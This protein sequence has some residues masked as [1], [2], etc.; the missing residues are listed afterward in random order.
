MSAALLAGEDEPVIRVNGEG[1]SP[2]VLVC[3]HAGR[4]IPKSLGT[5]ALTPRELESHIAWDI[6]AEGVARRLADLLDAPLFLQRYSRLVYDCNRPPDVQS[7][8]PVVSEVTRIPG[9]EHLSPEAK[10]ARV[11]ALYR[12]LHGAV[13]AFLDERAVRG[14]ASIF[15][16]IHSFTPV[17]KGVRRTLDLGILH[18][19]DSRF[20]DAMLGLCGRDITARRNEPYGPQDGV[21][22]TLNVHAE[23]R[24]LRNVMLEIRNDL[25]GDTNGQR[26]WAQRLATLL[27]SAAAPALQRAAS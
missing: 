6:G 24:G 11:E 9:N 26:S 7:A 2:F 13:V 5:L 3:E 14:V 15:V 12:P 18:D 4:Q 16:T 21:C 22:H 17:Y 20:A 8:I 23:I 27:Q 10:L 1:T 19:R 25:I